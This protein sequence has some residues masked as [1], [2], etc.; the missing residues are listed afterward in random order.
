M[1]FKNEIK[2]YKQYKQLLKKY[3]N[4]FDDIE[5]KDIYF[6]KYTVNS[7]KFDIDNDVYRFITENPDEEFT[8]WDRNDFKIIDGYLYILYNYVYINYDE[9]AYG[10]SIVPIKDEIIKKILLLETI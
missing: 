3:E 2:I 4:I 9:Y 5:L 1:T 7:I 10:I 8:V 6:S